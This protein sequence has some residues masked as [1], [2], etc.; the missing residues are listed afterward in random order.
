MRLLRVVNFYCVCVASSAVS[1]VSLNDTIVCYCVGSDENMPPSTRLRQVQAKVVASR[2]TSTLNAEDQ[3]Q[4]FREARKARERER[5]EKLR[6]SRLKNSSAVALNVSAA[7]S[8]TSSTS[9]VNVSSVP[10]FPKAIRQ[11]KSVV[12]GPSRIVSQSHSRSG[13]KHNHGT[14]VLKPRRSINGRRQA[15]KLKIE[16]TR[17]P[18]SLKPVRKYPK[19]EV[20]LTKTAELRML[21]SD[22]LLVP[23]K[24]SASNSHFK[25][26]PL[27]EAF[28]KSSDAEL[29]HKD[30]QVG[31]A[32]KMPTAVLSKQID[33]E[34]A[35]L[36]SIRQAP[37][38]SSSTNPGKKLG[39]CNP[40]KS[41]GSTPKSTP[42]REKLA[43]WL[44]NRDQSLENFKHL[45]CFGILGPVVKRPQTPFRK[46]VLSTSSLM[47]IPENSDS[48]DPEIAPT[49][50]D[51]CDEES[52]ELNRTFTMED[53]DKENICGAMKDQMTTSSTSRNGETLDAE[54][55]RHLDQAKGVLLELFN[56]IQMGYPVEQ[57]DQW[58][59]AVR[60]RF[61]QCGDEA[62]YWECLASLE[63]RCGDLQSAV[64]CYEQAIS[65][66]AEA[67]VQKSLDELLKKM[68]ALNIQPI[69]STTVPTQVKKNSQNMNPSNI[70]KSS[71]IQ[72]A[73][74]E[75]SSSC[76][77]DA[78]QDMPMDTVF[79]ATPVR[80]SGRLAV[81]PKQATPGVTCVRS[82]NF[83]EPQVRKSLW[84]HG[85]SALEQKD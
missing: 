5:L 23:S 55:I 7:I 79:T 72:F 11:P 21:K 36:A 56:L 32:N 4:Q 58:L 13:S 67:P 82:L 9:S 52:S 74:H 64:S 53:E 41:V 10:V 43:K 28:P 17:G 85:N 75:K 29:E 62:I 49:H 3:L 69:L 70:I 54:N 50:Q 47:A 84:F 76:R 22:P 57:S 38:A 33:K 1:F 30:R 44:E 78:H 80:R 35:D 40:P 73:V 34:Q 6:A 71:T 60:R 48:D 66:G 68:A 51:L 42:L 61:P 81:T 16:T 39:F 2:P 65:Q 46:T 24:L 59:R 83:L 77:K 14:N 27:P 20:K 15:S 63:E 18:R 31:K 37:K 25:I 19:A 45:K 26:L 12:D 8:I